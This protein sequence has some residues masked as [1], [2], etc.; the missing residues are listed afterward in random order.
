MNYKDRIKKNLS[1]LIPQYLQNSVKLMWLKKGRNSYIIKPHRIDQPRN[2]NIGEDVYLGDKSTLS[3][4]NGFLS[5]GNNVFATRYLNIYCGEKIIIEDNVLI[6]SFVLITDLSHGINPEL[7]QN[8]QKQQITTKPVFIG[9]GCWIGDKASI[10]PGSIIGH[11]A[12]IGS[13]S[14]VSG[15]IPPY[16]M[17][18]GN[19]AKVVKRWDFDNKEWIRV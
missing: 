5:I 2:I 8:Y 18:V 14:V 7:E 1:M 11:K 4:Y 12:V 15:I 3:C 16:T 19:P 10:L 9:R 17:A 6:S 13:N